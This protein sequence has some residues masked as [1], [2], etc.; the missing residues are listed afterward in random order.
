MDKKLTAKVQK[1]NANLSEIARSFSNATI[2]N[3]DDEASREKYGTLYTIYDVIGSIDLD[4]L[5]V[6]KIVHDVLHDSYYQAENTSPIQ[7]LEKAVVNVRDRVTKLARDAGELNPEFN[8][9]VTAL[10]G[11]VL[12]LV[13]YGKGGSYLMR[14]TVVKPIQAASEGNFT[15]ASGVVKDGDLVIIGTNKFL[16]LYTPETLINSTQPISQYDLPLE[17]SALILKF[18]VTADFTQNEVLNI[19]KPEEVPSISQDV[20]T[21][22]YAAQRL[23]VESVSY[24]TAKPKFSFKFPKL[25][26]GRSAK[27]SLRT[28]VAEPNRNFIKLAIPIIGVLFILS[29][30]VTV[31]ANKTDPEFL[32]GIFASKSQESASEITMPK[33][34]EPTIEG[35]SIDPEEDKRI[36]LSRVAAEVF[37][38][39]KLV[40]DTAKPA[41]MSVLDNVVLVGDS[42]SGKMFKSS[43]S[44]A[45][46]EAVLTSFPGTSSLSFI[47]GNVGFTDSE[48]YKVFN[49]ETNEVVESYDDDSIGKVS[50][51]YLDFIY[52]INGDTLTKYE[53][54]EDSLTSSTWGQSSDFTNAKSITIAI[55]IYVIT[56]EGTLVSYL[57]GQKTGFEVSGLDVAFRDPKQVVADLDFNNIYIADPGNKRV[58]VL[59]N[60][61]ALVQQY[62]HT[63]PN[64]WG[65]IKAIGVSRDEKTLFVLS[66]TKVYEVGLNTESSEETTPTSTE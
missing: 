2:I 8:I 66:G 47:D 52:A 39:L 28:S 20:S 10:W 19:A 14:D 4:T 15:V 36:K 31:I 24:N 34:V 38:D 37:Y 64:A 18:V 50:A 35:E 58:V 32:G 7:S 26:F 49:P 29:L 11:N 5:L 45:K 51:S 42:T 41:T 44:T 62:K 53:K 27:I 23:K 48:G 22:S 9:L 43:L 65:D 13:Q 17:A 40:D 54:S 6:T 33:E 12:Y 63:N 55:N 1:L 60:T 61:G 25:S 59:D 30:L 16:D 3:P 56:G 46:F 21:A 57:S